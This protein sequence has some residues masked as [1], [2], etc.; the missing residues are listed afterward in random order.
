MSTFK[1]LAAEDL[2]NVFFDLDEFADTH[3]VNSVSMPVIIDN[4]ELLERPSASSENAGIFGQSILIYVKAA[5]Y[6][7]RPRRDSIIM[8]DDL[9]YRCITSTEEDGVYAITIERWMSNGRPQKNF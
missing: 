3:T 4:N 8:L 6:G 5:L 2:G 9:K 7:E 1:E